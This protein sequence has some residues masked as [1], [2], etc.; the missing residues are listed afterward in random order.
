[1]PTRRRSR[2]RSGRTSGRT[3]GKPLKNRRYRTRRSRQ[4]KHRKR[5]RRRRRSRSTKM[6]GDDD[7]RPAPPQP[8]HAIVRTSF[9][10]F[11]S[12]KVLLSQTKNLFKCLD[13]TFK[14]Q[15]DIDEY[16]IKPSLNNIIAEIISQTPDT[17]LKNEAEVRAYLDLLKE[18]LDAKKG[19]PSRT[20]NVDEVKEL[21]AE[22][23]KLKGC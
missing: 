7:D 11:E 1:M 4:E 18:G 2:R 10:V 12:W 17:F 23:E 16:S 13:K 8:P 22:W 3:S 21:K 5:K 14:A 20:M 19:A 6:E 15:E 9:S